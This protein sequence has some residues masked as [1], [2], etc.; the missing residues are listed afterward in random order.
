MLPWVVR[1]LWKHHP[2]NTQVL[3]MTK[4]SHRTLAS[5]ADVSSTFN[6]PCLEGKGKRMR[7]VKFKVLHCMSHSQLSGVMSAPY[8]E[9]IWPLPV[10]QFI[11]LFL[12][13]CW[14][15]EEAPFSLTDTHSA[16]YIQGWGN[17]CSTAKLKPCRLLLII[18]SC[19]PPPTGVKQQKQK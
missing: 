15:L 6:S 12:K 14:W 10:F 1:V 13:A 11:Q 3:T 19:Q 8:F 2:V 18:Y 17:S 9:H 5:A 4:E 7:G 16:T